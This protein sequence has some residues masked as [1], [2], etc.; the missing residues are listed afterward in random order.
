MMPL[1]F[2]QIFLNVLSVHEVQY[3]LD[4]TD[5]NE[6]IK[7]QASPN[8]GYC[9]Y[10]LSC[11]LVTSAL[12]FMYKIGEMALRSSSRG[13]ETIFLFIATFG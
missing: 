10:R 7:I 9:F 11:S 6:A 4:E 3:G 12:N 13:S 5:Y 8:E 2:M 1:T